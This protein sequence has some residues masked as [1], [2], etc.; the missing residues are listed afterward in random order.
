MKPL[1][2][3]LFLV[4]FISCDSDDGPNVVKDFRDA[5]EAEITNYITN[6]NLTAIRSNS[7]L[8]YVIENLGT[9]E[10]PTAS[11]SVTVAYK[12]YYT[13]GTT[14]DAS[15]DDGITFSL[16]QVILGWTEGIQYFKEG[17]NGILLVPSHL[18][19]GSNNYNGIPGG[20]V[21]VFEVN[22]KSIN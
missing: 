16:N 22:L 19:Y 6:N 10:N 4:L 17:G 12:G 13:D 2:I 5:N 18:A 3:A 15:D 9:G 8:Y 20:S 14:F 11:S 21:L 7:G 1:F